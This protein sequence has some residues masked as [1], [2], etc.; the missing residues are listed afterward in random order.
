MQGL[1]RLA[2]GEYLIKQPKSKRSKRMVSMSPSLAIVLREHRLHQEAQS[3]ILGL[4][5]LGS[6]LVFSYADGNCLR[7]DSVTRAFKTLAESLGITGVHFHSLRHTHATL[8]LT[9]GVHP[10]VVQERLG[11][12]SIAITLDTYSHVAPGIQEAAAKKFDEVFQF[13]KNNAL[14]NG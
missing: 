1:H 9:Q 11:H 6:N 14:A 10:K 13:S 7:P 8:M 3:A 5:L 12:S 4:A 2:N